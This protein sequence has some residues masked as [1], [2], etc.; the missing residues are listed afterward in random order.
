MPN[1]VGTFAT[2]ENSLVGAE[3]GALYSEGRAGINDYHTSGSTLNMPEYIKFDASRSSSSYQDDAHVTPL[4]T[5]AMF[6]LKY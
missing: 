2:W 4:S 1:I 3:G 5:T 6:L